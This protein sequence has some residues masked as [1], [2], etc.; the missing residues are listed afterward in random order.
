MRKIACVLA[1]TLG[2]SS[3]AIAQDADY[4]TIHTVAIVSAIGGHVTLQTHGVTVFGN[5]SGSIA[6]DSDIDDLVTQRIASAVQARFAVKPVT[7]DAAPLRNM[8]FKRDSLLE[9]LHRWVLALPPNAI[10]AYIVVAGGNGPSM[11]MDFDGLGLMHSTGLLNSRGDT[12]AYAD[13]VVAVVD[14]K[15]GDTIAWA[16]EGITGGD[17][18]RGYTLDIC[19]AAVWDGS[20][21]I[22][23][24]EQKSMVR[25][26][27]IALVLKGLPRALAGAGLAAD[28]S[29]RTA[30]PVPNEP[31]TPFP[32]K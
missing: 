27:M 3:G 24:G 23:T 25:D 14:A 11:G 30:S 21:P 8:S 29:Q 1:A 19:P 26:E 20:S 2:I 6:L 31:C 22:L 10:D 12:I 7:F 4:S 9:Q 15:T 17:P 18:H 5:S 13:V 16:R 28:A 32:A